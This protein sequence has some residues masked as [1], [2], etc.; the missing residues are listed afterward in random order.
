MIPEA[1]A[2]PVAE[3]GPFRCETPTSRVATAGNVLLSVDHQEK[4]SPPFSSGLFTCIA[5][6]DQAIGS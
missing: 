4:L 2:V 5:L 1:S 3:V 6:S